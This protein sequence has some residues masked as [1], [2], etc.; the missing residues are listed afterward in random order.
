MAITIGSIVDPSTIPFLLDKV[1]LSLPED[2]KAGH[3][4]H[5]REH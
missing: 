3:S 5:I 2:E 1:L 4:E